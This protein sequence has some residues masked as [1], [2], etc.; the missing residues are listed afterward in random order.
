MLPSR[1]GA[2]SP[3][4]SWPSG[5]RPLFRAFA[6]GQNSNGSHLLEP[7]PTGRWPRP[8]SIAS[9]SAPRPSP[10]SP[11]VDLHTDLAPPKPNSLHLESEALL[12]SLFPRKGDPS[13]SGHHP[14]PGQPFAALQRTDCQ[15]GRAGKAGGLRDLPVGDHSPSG[16]FGDDPAETGERGPVAVP[17]P[18]GA[19]RAPRVASGRHDVGFSGAFESV[20]A[21][22][23][24]GSNEGGAPPALCGGPPGE[25]EKSA[26]GSAR[27]DRT[28]RPPNPI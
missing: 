21:Y 24:S 16:N 26:Y 20:P 12:P 6:R 19:L 13:A 4:P 18:Q 22:R 28:W 7:E 23:L 14:V 5:G 2:A 15:A 17:R 11:I 3:F 10:R 1:Y 9:R 27:G 25:T 8:G